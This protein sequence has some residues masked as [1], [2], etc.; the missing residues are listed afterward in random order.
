MQKGIEVSQHELERGK[1]MSSRFH[2][3]VQ[4]LILALGSA[5]AERYDLYSEL[6]LELEE[7]ESVP[8]IALFPK[9]D[10]EFRVGKDET[11]AKTAPSGVIE[12]IPSS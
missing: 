10:F 6:T 1:P 12:I 8:G 4:T 5:Y 3:R 7:W 2:S 9:A 11:R